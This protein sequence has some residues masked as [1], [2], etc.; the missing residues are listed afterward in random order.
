MKALEP[1]NIDNIGV[2][3]YEKKANNDGSIIDN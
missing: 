2:A 3:I 1:G